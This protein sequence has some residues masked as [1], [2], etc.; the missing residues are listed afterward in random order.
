MRVVN[1]R[2]D[3]IVGRI[4]CRLRVRATVGRLFR[5]GLISL[6]NDERAM[7]FAEDQP[8]LIADE[9]LWQ[10]DL[11]GS[12]TIIEENTLAG[13][14]ITIALLRVRVLDVRVLLAF[15]HAGERV[16]PLLPRR[17]TRRLR[18]KDRLAKLLEVDSGLA[19]VA[20][21]RVGGKRAGRT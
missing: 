17:P 20:D 14:R 5:S 7:V 12:A 8:A 16:E 6:D 1:E 15:E 2:R 11:R 19:L 9:N 4:G 13:K 3:P 10:L 21:I 18:A